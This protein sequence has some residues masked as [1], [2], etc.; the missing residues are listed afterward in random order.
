MIAPRMESVGMEGVF[1]KVGMSIM[2]YNKVPRDRLLTQS[3][4][5]PK[6]P[7]SGL[8]LNI[9][10]LP[11]LLRLHRLNMLNLRT[12]PQQLHQRRAR[13]LPQRWSMRVP[14]E[15]VWGW[16]REEGGESGVHGHLPQ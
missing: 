5:P 11:V 13:N 10:S 1:A 9:W 4:L 14:P 12:L 3:V 16:V 8:L 7:S 6:L 15:V 2:V